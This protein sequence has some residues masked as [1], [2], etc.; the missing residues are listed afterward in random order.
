MVNA[1]KLGGA[2]QQLYQSMQAAINE[3]V[4]NRKWTSDTYQFQERISFSMNI[5]LDERLSV[6][7]FKATVQIQSN[8]PVFNSGY[9]TVMLN[10]TDPDWIF[11]YT[12]FQ[13][14]EFDINMHQSNL[15]SMLAFYVYT[16]LGLDY[17]TFGLMGGQEF[18][19]KA[20]QIVNNAQNAQEMGWRQ[21]QSLRNRY[22]LNENLTNSSYRNF[23]E[24]LYTYHRQG[25]DVMS[26]PDNMF[27]AR[28][29]T[30]EA[31][32]KLHQL[33]KSKPGSVILPLFLKGK[34]NEIVGIYQPATPAE[35]AKVLNFLTEMDPLNAQEYQKINQ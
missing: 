21:S 22:W 11:E 7:Q 18:H 20:K 27:Q 29:K 3:F 17:D 12:E 2:D 4:N 28:M 25:L 24:F 23:R 34:V 10:Y 30:T 19:Q 15:T 5:V 32:E 13:P 6:N 8:R 1:N 31:I 14:L 26:K 35:K 16:V 9:T 33:Y